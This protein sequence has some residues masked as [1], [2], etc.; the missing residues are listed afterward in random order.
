MTP[1]RYWEEWDENTGI[2]WWNHGRKQLNVVIRLV[3]EWT[4]D[5]RPAEKAPRLSRRI[6]MGLQTFGKTDGGSAWA[7]VLGEMKEYVEGS[8][9]A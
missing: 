4:L 8:P 9:D 7:V 5:G 3:N 6:D 2:D 1:D